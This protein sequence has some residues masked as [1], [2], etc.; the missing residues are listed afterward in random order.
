MQSDPK[1][2]PHHLAIPYFIQPREGATSPL[3]PDLTIENY[4]TWARIMRRALN[5]NNKFGFVDGKISKPANE[6]DPLFT[7][8][9]RCN[10]MVIA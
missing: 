7:P 6:S 4:L 1:T 10:D 9:E 3:V 5:I 8:W 2:N